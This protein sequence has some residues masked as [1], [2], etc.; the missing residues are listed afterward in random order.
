MK[1]LFIS[2]AITLLFLQ[3]CASTQQPQPTPL[4]APVE[5]IEYVQGEFNQE[6]LYDL[7]LAEMAGQQR[8]FP[9]ALERYLAQANKTK[10]P[11]VAERATRI[12][13]YLRNPEKIQQS[14]NLWRIADPSNPEP[15][16]IEANLLLHRNQ[17]Q[18][19]LPLVEKAMSFDAIRTLALIRSQGQKLNK[20]VLPQYIQLLQQF[21]ED[22]EPMAELE[23]T[24]AVLLRAAGQNQAALRALDQTLLLNPDNLEAV[25]QKADLLQQSNASPK[26]LKLAA[27][28]FKKHPDH[29]QLNILYIQL[30]FD[31]N[32]ADAGTDVAQKM[33][34]KHKRD[35]QLTYYLA[36]LMLENQQLTAAASALENL[37]KLQPNDSSP[38]FYLGHIAQNQS[39]PEEAIGHYTQVKDG[40]NIL[41][42]YSRVIG[43]LNTPNDKIRVQ[44]ILKDARALVPD[45][46][47]NIFTL[48][49]E[50]LNLHNFEEEAL[51]LLDDALAAHNDNTT[52]LYTRAMMI[53]DRDFDRAEQDFRRILTL[54]PDNSSVKNALGYTL[55]LHTERYNEAYDLIKAALDKQPE[56]P[57]IIDSM[58]W[59]LFKLGR[60]DE[61]VTYLEKAY[62]LF[63]DPEVASHLI[64]AYW[65]VGLKTQALHLLEQSKADNPD[66]PYLQEAEQAINE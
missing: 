49:A 60:H 1:K 61:A 50:W 16:Q 2:I 18:A 46:T 9:L 13:Q 64:Q 31:N 12:A 15:Y 36:L 39:Q 56:D 24:L 52:L 37:L 54:E 48:E 6:S 51:I 26:A 43:L 66:N 55:L 58:G 17:Y 4:S 47:A 28:Y 21:A 42:A 23:L 34:A 27:Q 7:L 38:H 62:N 25:L 19:A 10:D 63:A 5:P 11:A 22:S 57:A 65:A 45:Q 20:N 29:R 33:L 40:N 8:Q 44:Q 41:P 14:A 53:E 59:V 3:G 35:Q 32:N 30:L